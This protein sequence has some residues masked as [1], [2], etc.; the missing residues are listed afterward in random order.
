MARAAEPAR[1][2]IVEHVSD[3]QA[4]ASIARAYD[5]ILRAADRRRHEREAAAAVC[6]IGADPATPLSGDGSH[7]Q[8]R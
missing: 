1:R 4:A 7:A 2:I 6:L 5:I 8:P 3:A